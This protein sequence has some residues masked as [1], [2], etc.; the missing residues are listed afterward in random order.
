LFTTAAGLVTAIPAVI[1]Y[2]Q[3]LAN[4]R[5]LAQRLDTFTLEVAA[6]IEK[7]FT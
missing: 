2:N 6:Q 3:F 4:I 1:F 7:T 5:N